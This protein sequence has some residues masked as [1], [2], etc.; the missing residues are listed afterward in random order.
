MGKSVHPLRK[1]R[2]NSLNNPEKPTLD[3]SQLCLY[4][5]ALKMTGDSC[6][7]KYYCRSQII[8]N[9]NKGLSSR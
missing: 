7:Q 3:T 2:E 9:L 4:P 1:T 8:A 6:A 5:R